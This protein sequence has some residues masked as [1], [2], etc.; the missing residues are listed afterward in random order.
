ML[1]I[2]NPQI[3][4]VVK[5]LEGKVILVYGGNS[6]GKTM[7]GSRMEKPLILPFEKGLNAIDG[8]P[9]M[10][11]NDWAD[12][13]RVN[14]QLTS[15]AT[16]KKAREQYQTI[17]FDEI[18]A[19]AIYCQEYICLKHGEESIKTGNDGYG[20]WKEYEVE[21]WREINRLTGAGYTVYFIA[22]AAKDTNGK[23]YPKGD[24]R[25]I[26]PIQDI[27][28]FTIYLH[29]SGV[30]ENGQVIKS[31]GFT[32]ETENYFARSRFPY[33]TPHLPSFTAEALEDAIREAIEL[34]EKEEGVATISF[35]EK[36]KNDNTELNYDEIL[37]ELKDEFLR[38][39]E[40]GDEQ[41]LDY[42]KIVDEYLGKDKT[43]SEATKDQV[44]ILSLI[45]DEVKEIE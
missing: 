9:Y 30:D 45:L 32:A 23:L 41:L 43:V 13:K 31:Q 26:A 1:D 19:S 28:D 14:R 27:A 17:I 21:Y 15:P 7:Q 37:N 40:L 4:K 3:S 6:L 33:M 35:E 29:P 25:A 42:K 20:L 8:V 11:I 39:Q 5:G 34:Q 22:H 18:N 24:K 2:F 10:P 44:S 12:F 16:V 36:I 38:I